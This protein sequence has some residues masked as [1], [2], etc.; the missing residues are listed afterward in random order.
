MIL[1]LYL[2]EERHI[3][4]HQPNRLYSDSDIGGNGYFQRWAQTGGM[5]IMEI[6]GLLRLLGEYLCGQ[7]LTGSVHGDQIDLAII[8]TRHRI[9][10]Q[11]FLD[12]NTADK[13]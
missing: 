1:F 12:V 9:W 10:R 5:G 11:F 3:I 4:L 6:E 13:S 7:S 8:K 2:Q